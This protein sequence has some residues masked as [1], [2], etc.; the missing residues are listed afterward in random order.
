MSVKTTLLA[1]GMLAAI[2]LVGC[3]E[4]AGSMRVRVASGT[5]YAEVPSDDTTLTGCVKWYEDT[6]TMGE[7]VRFYG[8]IKWGYKEVS[9]R[10]WPRTDGFCHF[11]VPYINLDQS[12][13][14]CT[15][16]YYQKGH[17]DY[18]NVYV[19]WLYT[20]EDWPGD[21]EELFWAIQNSDNDSMITNSITYQQNGLH[22]VALLPFGNQLVARFANAGGGYLIT[23]WEYP[24]S[25]YDYWTSVA[26]V[27]DSSPY[28]K[29]C[30]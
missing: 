20:V 26:G 10:A 25:S 3:M 29:I 15:L 9:G 14:T 4:Q 1:L 12:V 17:L 13:P 16:F 30:Y 7:V 28:I 21:A 2:V 27:G 18:P 8:D 5:R 6:I 19:K 23:G 22:S 11:E 24:G